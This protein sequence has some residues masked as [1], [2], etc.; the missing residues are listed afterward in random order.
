MYWTNAKIYISF[1]F[2]NYTPACV[3]NFSPKP[4]NVD[5]DITLPTHIHFFASELY[6][7]ITTITY[8]YFWINT[9]KIKG[10]VRDC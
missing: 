5:G 6:F 8:I 4:G 10:A 7:T 1:T 2:L 9:L 3:A